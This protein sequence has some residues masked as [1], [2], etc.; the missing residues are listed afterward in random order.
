MP[1]D[2]SRNF[3]MSRSSWG[4]P[5]IQ[6]WAAC[7]YPQTPAPSSALVLVERFPRTQW[8]GWEAGGLRAQRCLGRINHSPV[9]LEPT[10]NARGRHS[11]LRDPDRHRPQLQKKERVWACVPG[12]SL[13]PVLRRSGSS[14]LLGKEGLRRGGGG[15]TQESRQDVRAHLA[16]QH[17]KRSTASSARPGCAEGGRGQHQVRSG[18]S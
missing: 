9:L 4:R 1:W 11:P 17:P 13:Q 10:V 2:N 8:G 3:C 15:G 14:K 12:V 6:A 7:L 5:S 18:L 16:L